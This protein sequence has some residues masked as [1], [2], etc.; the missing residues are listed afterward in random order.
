MTTATASVNLI[1]DFISGQLVTASPE[2]VSAVQVFSRILV[3]EFNYPKAHIRTRPQFMVREAPSGR[4]TYP[5]DIAVFNSPRHTHD[6][7]MMLIECKR[8]TIKEGRRQLEIYLNLTSAQIAVWYNGTGSLYLRKRIEANGSFKIEELHALPRYGQDLSDIGHLLRKHL[9]PPSNLKA[10]FQA[11]RNHLAGTSKGLTRDEGFARE[12]INLLFCKIY[13]ELNTDLESPVRFY[14]GDE[15]PGAVKGRIDHLFS[16]VK[17]RYDDVFDHNDLVELDPKSVAYV[18]GQL[19]HLLITEADTD[20]VADAFETFIGPALKGSQGQFFTPRN[21]VRMMV[22]VIDPEPEHHLIDPACGSGGF[23]IFA[24]RH[25]WQ[26]YDALAKARGWNQKQLLEAKRHAASRYFHGMEKDSFLAKVTKAY[27]AIVGDGRGGVFCDDA[28][29]RPEQ[30]PERVRDSIQLG[31]FSYVFTNPP[32]GTK[33]KVEGEATLRQ[34]DLGHDWKKKNG[35]WNQTQNVPPT[36]PPQILFIDRCLQLLAPGGK[37][38]IVLPESTFG[39]P[40]Y[41][42]VMTYLANN[43]KILGL[44]SMPEDLFQ[45]YTHAKACVLFAEKTIPPP[46][47]PSGWRR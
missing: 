6:N 47:T 21:V 46:T 22:Q 15:S 40:S 23:L 44:V 39:N 33:I 38:A 27:M 20:A 36:K 35:Q 37:L 5:V 19:Q 9:S 12:L 14:I 8:P 17:R 32:F 10:T 7:L 3:E 11:I 1:E 28:L 13:D 31:T 29:A 41:G 45:P 26:K 4:D 2:E 34:Y 25:V 30:W 18:V 42:Y 24:L 16:E 43:V